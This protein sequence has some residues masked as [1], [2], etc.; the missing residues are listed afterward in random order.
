VPE[1][2]IQAVTVRLAVALAVE[3]V[4]VHVE[5]D[6]RALVPSWLAT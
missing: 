4:R 5:R 6:G 3:Q 2:G 1:V